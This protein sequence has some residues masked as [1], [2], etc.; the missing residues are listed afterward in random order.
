MLPRRVVVL[1]VALLLGVSLSACNQANQPSPNLG[2]TTTADPAK[3][4]SNEVDLASKDLVSSTDD[5]V[6]QIASKPEFQNP[7][8]R[9]N[10]V[11]DRVENK[12]TLPSRNYDIYLARVRTKLNES[13]A[14][15]NIGFVEKRATVTAIRQSEGLEPPP[16]SAGGYKSKADYA[17]RGV[18]YDMPNVGSNYYLLTF[19]IVDLNDGEI[20]YEGSYE[21]KF[22]G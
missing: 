6:A 7:P 19:Q 1:G 16:G 4:R 17:L 12:T 21:S 8:Y 2:R 10:I 18:F 20:V 11:M 15:Y 3:R 14:R 5:I 13:G 9:I 22:A